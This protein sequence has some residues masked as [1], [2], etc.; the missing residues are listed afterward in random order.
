MF[1]FVRRHEI[2][3]THSNSNSKSMESEPEDEI[4]LKG[5]PINLYLSN[6]T[7]FLFF[8]RKVMM[9]SPI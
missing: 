9:F 5:V 3:Q 4:I 7:K 2:V 6:L 1:R 8:F